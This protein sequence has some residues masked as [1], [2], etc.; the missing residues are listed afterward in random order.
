MINRTTEPILATG[1]ILAEK[2]YKTTI[3][4]VDA[5]D[6]DPIA[7]ISNGDRVTVDADKGEVTI[8]PQV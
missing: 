3:P 4:V 6:K 8:Y 1:A 5:F 2:F 7:E